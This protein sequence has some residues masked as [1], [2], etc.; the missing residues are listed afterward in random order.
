MNK[1][2]RAGILM[3]IS[4]LPSDYGIGTLGAH[5]EKFIDFLH[6]AGIKI[7]QTLPLLPTNYG[8][9]PYQSC[10][11]SALNYYFI[12]FDL[13]K[14]QKLLIKDDYANIDWGNNPERIDYEKLFLHKAKVLKIAFSRFD[15]SDKAWQNFLQS[16]KYRDF[17]IFMTLKEKFDY[18]PFN[19]WQ[20]YAVYDS[21]KIAEFTEK[22]QQNIEFWIFTQYIFLKQWHALKD[23][24]HEKGIEIMGDMP[25]YVAYDSVEMWKYGKDLFL[26]DAKNNPAFVAGVPPDVFSDDGQLWGNPVYNWEKMCLDGYSWWHNRIDYALTLFDIVRIDHFRGFDRFYAIPQGATSAKT[27]EWMQ[28]PSAKLFEGRTDRNIVAEDLGIIDDGVREMLKQTGY[29][30]MKVLEFAF[31]GSPYNEHKPSNY[32]TNCVAYTGTHDNLPLCAFIESLSPDK[33]ESFK[34]ELKEECI[35]LNV[36]YTLD[37]ANSQCDT[38]ISLLFASKAF[39]AVVPLQDVLHLGA[40][41]RINFPSTLS[42]DNWSFRFSKN[43]FNKNIAKRLQ[44]L[45]N[46]YER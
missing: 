2:R 12:D 39:L 33:L 26:L 46:K 25:I 38:A 18:R 6:V 32:T 10:D 17:A 11:S 4:A 28:G 36:E 9:S 5:A 7:W 14:K 13:L 43:H 22:N 15:K 27:G 45:I 40:Y 19:E 41:A 35:K 20:D 34:Q 29:P 16:G 44:R 8:D 1:Q 24:A 30:G 42:P 37:D 21:E 3:P 31:D 23:Y